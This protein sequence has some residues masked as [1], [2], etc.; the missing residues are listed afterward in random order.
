M[1]LAHLFAPA[2]LWEQDSSSLTQ[3]AQS[4]QAAQIRVG[5]EAEL[6]VPVEDLIEDPE[7]EP[8]YTDNPSAVDIDEIVDFFSYGNFGMSQSDANRLRARMQHDY[9]DHITELVD[10]E[11]LKSGASRIHKLAAQSGM[12]SDQIEHMMQTES[13]PY[14]QLTDQVE[15]QFR[16]KMYQSVS[17]T[18]WLKSQNLR[19][20]TDVAAAYDLTWPVWH[21]PEHAE[22][23]AMLQKVAEQ[24]TQH[25]GVPVAVSTTYHGAPRTP[26]TWALEPDSSIQVPDKHTH[27]GLELITP[28]PPPSLPQTVSLMHDVF[29]WAYR[30]GCETNSS[31]GFHMSMSLPEP[32]HTQIDPVKLILQLGDMQILTQFHRQSNTYAKSAFEALKAHTQEAKFPVHKALDALRQGMFKIAHSHMGMPVMNKYF[33]VH[34]KPTYVEFR[35]VG[36]DYLQDVEQIEQIMIR[37]A[38]ALVKSADPESAK[39]SYARK[40]YKLLTVGGQPD[41]HDHMIRLFSLYSAGVID[42]TQLKSYIA[43][44]R[45]SER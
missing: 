26:D 30:T 40:L 19:H 32:M 36:G 1:K 13:D 12:T 38:Q 39:K 5:F 14:D 27:A 41:P 37:M 4:E 22:S 15:D 31:T 24:I 29:S 8:D 10:H 45:L 42:V 16:D 2:L 25:V 11:F 34:I 3:F 33:S 23:A 6:V 35:H 7:P 18:A 17:E 43:Q 44:A 20:M 21:T 28:S 9:E